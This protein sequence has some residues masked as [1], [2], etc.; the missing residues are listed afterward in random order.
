MELYAYN[1]SCM[2]IIRVTL[3]CKLFIYNLYIITHNLIL[4]ICDRSIQFV[5]SFKKKSTIELG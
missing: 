1:V 2:Y 3:K 4:S 5:I